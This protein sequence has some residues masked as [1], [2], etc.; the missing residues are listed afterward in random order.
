MSIISSSMSLMVN[1][2]TAS[3][4]TT[5]TDLAAIENGT[6]EAPE[7]VAYNLV[8]VNI[9]VKSLGHIYNEVII[10]ATTQE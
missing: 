9:P 7:G 10:G 5:V 3:G 1:R 4:I 8:T 2:D 6:Y